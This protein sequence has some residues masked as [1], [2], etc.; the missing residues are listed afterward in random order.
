MRFMDADDP[1]RLR[2]SRTR[3]H[4][5]RRGRSRDD[6]VQRISAEGRG[7]ARTDGLHPPS[8][9]ARVSSSP[10]GKPKTTDG[11]FAEAKEVVGGYWMIQVKSRAEAVEWASR[12]PASDN[13]MIE[14]C[15]VMEFSD[16]S[17]RRQGCR[18]GVLENADAVRSEDGVVKSQLR[19]ASILAATPD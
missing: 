9:G 16:F 8:M 10:V 5:G 18:R 6:E 13:E 19:R 15:Q 1:Q 3:Y 17:G 7:V 12:C 11:P 2:E 14:V 4:A